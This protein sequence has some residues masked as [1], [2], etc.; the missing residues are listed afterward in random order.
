M[1]GALK[2]FPSPKKDFYKVC[3]RS[4]TYNQILFVEDCLRGVSMQKTDFPFV[5]QVVDDCSTDGQQEF[6]KLYIERECDLSNAEYYDNDLCSII[7]SKYRNNA[8]CTLVVYFLKKNLYEAQE[9]KRFL[10]MSWRKV[11]PYEAICEGDDYWTDP[12]KLKRQVEFLDINESYSVIAEN[13]LVINEKEGTEYFFGEEEDRDWSIGEMIIKRRFP[14]AGVLFRQKC[15]EGF[16]EKCRYSFDSMMWCYL[17][18]N[19]NIRYSKIVSSVYR[20]GYGVTET[21][22]KVY[23]AKQVE[24]WYMEF[25]RLY[26]PEFISQKEINNCVLRDYYNSIMHNSI[27]VFSKDM[28]FCLK[29]VYE[30]GGI[31]KALACLSKRIR[32]CIREF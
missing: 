24:L 3:V 31:Y 25:K 14:T 2:G 27:P 6:I 16:Y 17:G 5:H 15:M 12:M 4:C 7:I 28:F 20:R 11:C 10:Y 21:T 30:Y 18:K 1:K 19:G 13:A 32:R 26:F 29:K 22:K 8:N 23:W 9:K